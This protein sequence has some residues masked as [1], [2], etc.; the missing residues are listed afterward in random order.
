MHGVAILPEHLSLTPIKPKPKMISRSKS[1]ALTVSCAILALGLASCKKQIETLPVGDNGIRF[2]AEDAAFDTATKASTGTSVVSSL[3]SFYVSATTGTLGSESE[4]WT[5]VSFSGSTLYSG[6]KYWPHTDEGYHF[7]ASNNPMVFASTSPTVAAINTK[8]VVCAYLPNPVYKEPN[9]LT[10]EHIFARVG[11]VSLSA[12]PSYTITN[13]SVTIVP[14]VSGTYNVR[15]GAGWTNGTGWSGTSNGSSVTIAASCPGTQENDVWLV[16]GEYTLLAT[17]TASKDWNET[18][19]AYDYIRTFTNIPANVNL[20]AGKVNA[21]TATLGGSAKE[22]EFIVII[23]PWGSDTTNASFSSANDGRS[24]LTFS[25][26]GSNTLSLTNSGGNAPS[27]QYSYNLHDWYAWDYSALSFNAAKP[28]YI[29]GSNPSGFSSSNSI[30][31]TFTIGGAGFVSCTGN[32]MSLINY[33]TPPTTIPSNYCFASAF[34]DCSKLTAAPLLPATTLKPYCYA[35]MFNGCSNLAKAPALPAAG[36]SMFCY[37]TMFRNCTSLTATPDLPATA[38]ASSCYRYMF[39][40]CTGIT[41]VPDVLPATT[42]NDSC[43]LG[44]F[45][46]CTSLTSAPTLP[47]LT[48]VNGCYSNMFQNCSSLAYI[49]AMF[50]TTPSTTYTN[51]WVSSV[52][53]SGTFAKNT[54]A[55][56]S[57]SGTYGVPSGWSTTSVAY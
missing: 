49:K 55:S 18:T 22:I 47:A 48:L 21:I 4:K 26:T 8:D 29:C 32:I 15:T 1:I 13:V 33:T 11:N 36:L 23:K 57:V 28:L 53:A 10:F 40:G 31:S 52:A 34:Q 35:N 24:Y 44:M 3:S 30:K 5:S 6:G 25:S 50:T 37:Q 56:W 9:T 20:V 2:F 7:Y 41:V 46:G 19:G 39:E 54:A 42:L 51:N 38:L 12:M 27:L 14:K 17:W 45:Y 16:P 43:Y